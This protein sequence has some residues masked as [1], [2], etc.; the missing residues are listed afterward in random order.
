ML[1]SLLAFIFVLGVL[2]ILHEGGHFLAARL[3]HAPV[4]VFSVGIGK[5]LW[6]FKRGGTDY[7]IS[8]LPL[9]GY[10]RVVGLG[11]DESDLAGATDVEPELLP[12][13]KRTIILLAGPAMNIVAAV[14]FLG[15]AFVLGVQVPAYQSRPPVVG[16]VEPASPAA[17]AGILPGDRIEAV[18]STKIPT[19]QDLENMILTSGGHQVRLKVIR[20]GHELS[21][22][23]TPKRITRYG[24]GY[25]GILPPL[26]PVVRGLQ[27]GS[28]AERCG[29]KKGD[30]I[31]AVNSHP[32]EQ[33]YDLIRLISPYPGQELTLSVVRGTT[34]LSLR[35]TPRNIG[36][37]GKIGIPVIF[38]THMEKLGVPGALRA[39]L[40]ENVRMTIETFRVIGRLVS[41]KASLSQVSGPLDI[42][43]ISGQA[44]RSGIRSLIWLMGL[45]SL[46][47]GIFNLLPIPLLDGGH[48]TIIAVET[49][50]RRD[51]S[52]KVKERIMEVGFVLLMLLMVV[53]LYNDILKVLPANLY[54]MLHGG[55]TP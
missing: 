3:V 30:R 8:L 12:K 53:V 39:S 50:I 23:M 48:L 19:W 55:G 29:L 18:D 25:S 2:V 16:W 27:P 10:V 34:T 37:K 46:Q 17:A 45:I 20:N 41:R 6:G 35:V 21:I 49:A 36:G 54:R 43:R 14:A 5:R 7:R 24:F 31:V 9:G 4:D 1:I 42:A 22:E 40:S 28:P 51:L 15:F 32:V 47:L 11:P 13:W 33:F 26:A 38:P 52:I 44:A